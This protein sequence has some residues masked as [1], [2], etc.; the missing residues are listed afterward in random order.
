MKFLL[1][2]N[3]S[4]AVAAAL[5]D[6][7][8]E[9]SHVADVG[10]LRASDDEILELAASNDCVVITADADFPIMLALRG[11]E[12][13]SVILVRQVCELSR[14]GHA[15][16]LRANLPRLGRPRQRSNRVLEPVPAGGTQPAD[17]LKPPGAGRWASVSASKWTLS[18]PSRLSDW[19]S[20][21]PRRLGTNPV[22]F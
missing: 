8:C 3:L 7:G 19:Q 17:R 4:P 13:S 18:T 11:A 22:L 2:A 9:A 21:L 14:E 12:R 5:N 20:E 16:L 1:D 15:R 10:P 6:A